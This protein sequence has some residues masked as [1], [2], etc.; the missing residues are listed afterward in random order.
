MMPGGAGGMMAGMGGGAGR[1]GGRN[2]PDMFGNKNT[3]ADPKAYRVDYSKRRLRAELYTVQLALGPKK[4]DPMVKGLI[5]YAKSEPDTK[6]LKGINDQ[7]EEVIKIVET[8]DQSAVDFEKSLRK[9]MTKLENLTKKLPVAKAEP[10]KAGAAKGPAVPGDEV[11]MAAKPAVEEPTEEI[12]MAPPAKGSAPAAA[13]PDAGKA[14]PAAGKDVPPP[15]AAPAG[16][17]P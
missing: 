9:E 15:P 8:Q 14:P 12:P 17:T 10:A 4:K 1:R 3:V 11:P 7:V 13:P 2:Q 16:K 5:T 6:T